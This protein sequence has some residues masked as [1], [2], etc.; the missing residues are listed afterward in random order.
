MT[1]PRHMPRKRPEAPRPS[2]PGRSA[3]GLPAHPQADAAAGAGG[4]RPAV[5]GRGTRRRTADPRGPGRGP[6]RLPGPGGRTTARDP[7]VDRVEAGIE[8]AEALRPGLAPDAVL[9]AIPRGGVEVA[10]VVAE[11]LTLPLDIVVPRKLGAPGNPELG[12]GAIA[13][14]VRVLDERLIGVAGGLRCVSER[15][16]RPAG[17]RDPS[18]DH[19]VPRG[20]GPRAGRRADGGGDRRR[21]RHRGTALAALRWARRAGAREV[22]F[23]AP[24]AP[25]EALQRLR[26]DADRVIILWTPRH[27]HAVG[28]WY[29]EFSQVD[30]ERVIALL[31]A[32]AG[33]P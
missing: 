29:V 31:R 9:L 12:L 28:Q 15:G 20:P 24:V 25:F 7:F 3:R 1:Y 23:A 2:G 4:A 13:E 6:A 16:D 32:A 26:A 10:A 33:R 30:D 21:R 5:R 18:Q 17:V 27:F 19:G 11:R 14:G 22:V 8:L